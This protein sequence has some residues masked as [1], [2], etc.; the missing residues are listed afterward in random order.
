[1]FLQLLL[2]LYF[3]AYCNSTESCSNLPTIYDKCPVWQYQNYNGNCTCGDSLESVVH[4]EKSSVYIQDCFCMTLDDCQV[5]VVGHCFY[6]CYLWLEKPTTQLIKYKI[7]TKNISS[8]SLRMC[9][10]YN[11]QGLLCSK[12]TGNYS[13]SINRY[14]ASC[15]PCHKNW[16]NWLK[17][18]T[19]VYVP[20]TVFIFAV[21]LLRFNANSGSMVAY[22]TLSQILANKNIVRLYLTVFKGIQYKAV[23]A[24]YTMWNLGFLRP[25]ISELCVDPSLTPLQ[26]LALDYLVAIYPHILIFLAYLVVSCHGRSQLVVYLCRPLY[27]CL[28]CFRKEWKIG[29]SLIEAFATLF[30]LSFSEI[31][32]ISCDILTYMKYNY[33]NKS[34]SRLV[35]YADP[36]M[37]YLSK[38]HLPYFVLAI[39][40]LL[41]YNICPLLALIL[42][43]CKFFQNCLKQLPPNLR[44]WITTYLDAFSGSYKL[45]PKFFQSFTSV[46]LIA[47]FTNIFIFHLTL[48]HT[49]VVYVLAT[50]LLLVVLLAPYKSRWHNSVNVVLISS[51]IF[52]NHNVAN[53]FETKFIFG[54]NATLQQN[55]QKVAISIGFLVL[56]AYGLCILCHYLVPVRVKHCMSTRIKEWKERFASP[57]LLDNDQSD[58]ILDVM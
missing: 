19:A 52:A 30:L 15:I 25:F 21:I 9:G 31:L 47:N 57:A 58:N 17:Y 40:M 36:N 27:S 23:I 50:L 41:V 16:Y 33:M 20:L 18:I 6:S 38:N 13:L 5:P 24:T 29:N 43:P 3:T 45:K 44:K 34:E 7:E 22:I 39:V 51:G 32:S 1:M 26:V 2:V 42:Y 55:L 35:V 54:K 8:L 56:P 49:G 12:C 37:L 46:Y 10:R 28:H 48:Y 14:H 53:Y 4:C 11:R